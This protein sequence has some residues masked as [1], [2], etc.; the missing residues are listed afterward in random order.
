MLILYV[1][2]SL[3]VLSSEM[4]PTGIEQKSSQSHQEAPVSKRRTPRQ[5]DV[6]TSPT[7]S[8]ASGD[9]KQSAP[10]RTK[11]P[12]KI[13]AKKIP[14]VR[15]PIITEKKKEAQMHVKTKT[16]QDKARPLVHLP[17]PEIVS[18]SKKIAGDVVN[19]VEVHTR[20]QRENPS[21]FEWRHNRITASTAHRISHSR[22]VNGKSPTP[23]ASYLAA[24]TGEGPNVKTRAMSWGIERE[25]EA[26]R[27]YQSLKSKALGR[28]VQVQ[29]CGL[30]IDSQRPWLAASPD[31][32]VQELD[33]KRLLCLEVK[34]PYKHRQNTVAQACKEDK[35]FCLEIQEGMGYCL[36][37]KHSYYTQIQCQM[38]VTGLHQADLVVFTL[39]ETAIVP[40]AYDPVFWET[41]VAKLE[42]FYKDGVL[43][44]AREKGL[45]IPAVKPEE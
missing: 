3:S 33:G 7:A 8:G 5:R 12:G 23:A 10:G 30:F 29:E 32:I 28:P 6:N 2:E 24:I 31:G 22:F 44:Y 21:W 43:P 42:L 26:V 36:K 34:C 40:V 39:E 25:A 16:T 38:A 13:V 35:T 37:P 20:G 27:H 14:E 41:T 11:P 19:A 17:R 9:S 15:Y 18:L 1:S 45:D 4:L